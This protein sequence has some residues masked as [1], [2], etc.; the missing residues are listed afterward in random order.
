M[1]RTHITLKLLMALLILAA[2]MPCASAAS[3]NDSIYLYGRVKEAL[4]KHDLTD[5]VVYMMD[6]QGN[7]TDSCQCNKG[8]SYIN[9][10]IIDVSSFGFTVPKR[11]SVYVMDVKCPK[12]TTKTITYELKNVGKREQWRDIPVIFLERAPRE[13]GEVT[14]TATKIKFYNRGDTV[15]YNADAFELAEGS[16]LDAL[17]SQ[18]PGWN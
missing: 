15:V 5:A 13:L 2:G 18:L 3:S 10:E 6:N 9:G 14:V 17:V 4:G 12:Y 7:P 11:D 1:E 8:K 16:M